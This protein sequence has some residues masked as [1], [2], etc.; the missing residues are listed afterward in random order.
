MTESKIVEDLAA[1]KKSLENI[2]RQS[3]VILPKEPSVQEL[4]SYSHTLSNISMA[5][6]DIDRAIGRAGEIRPVP[7]GGDP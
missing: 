5:V 3:P 1:V 7:E 6:D 4:Y 2:L